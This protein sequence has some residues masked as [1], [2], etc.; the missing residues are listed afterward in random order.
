[1]RV[2]GPVE[3][4][5]WRSEP[6]RRIVTELLCYLVLH[7]NRPVSADALR[8][9]LWPDE[10]TE[11]SATS[12]R[13]Y[14]SRL[15][16][17]L[18]AE[19]LPDAAKTGGYLLSAEVACDWD[20]CRE[21]LARSKRDAASV[22]QSDRTTR[23]AAVSSLREALSV[24]RGAPFEG[25]PPGSFGWAWSERIISEMEV[26]IIEAAHALSATC[27]VDGDDDTAAWAATRGL[28][29][30]P[31]SR[32]LWADHLRAAAGKGPEGLE[33]ASRDALAVLGSEA[34]DIVHLASELRQTRTN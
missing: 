24:V 7:R 12:L 3:V 17:S 31:Y 11:A 18:G 23:C 26:A 25:V 29:V 30:D 28:L 20:R 22:Q 33:R 13:S 5:G 34:A 10:D 14:V 6:N 2:L 4:I 15:R 32:I 16:Q 9:A 19:L 21:L 1:V 8:A 27:L